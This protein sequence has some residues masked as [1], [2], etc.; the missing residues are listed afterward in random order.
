MPLLSSPSLPGKRKLFL[1]IAGIIGGALLLFSALSLFSYLFLLRQA[2]VEHLQSVTEL[3]AERGMAG[4]GLQ[5]TLAPDTGIRGILRN[6]P[7]IE[8]AAIYDLDNALLFAYA[9]PG[10]PAI[11]VRPEYVAKPGERFFLQHGRIKCQLS[12]PIEMQGRRLGTVHL[13]SNT[14]TLASHLGT[15]LAFMGGSFLLSLGLALIAAARLQHH[16]RQKIIGSNL[17]M[18]ELITASLQPPAEP[19]EQMS[20]GSREQAV[21][22]EPPGPAESCDGGTQ[23]ICACGRILPIGEESANSGVMIPEQELWSRTRALAFVGGDEALL[24]ELAMVFLDRNDRLLRNIETAITHGA[25]DDLLEAAHAYRGA[26]D[27]FS[28]PVLRQ[29]AMVLENMARN[30]QVDGADVYLVRLRENSHLLCDELSQ[31]IIEARRH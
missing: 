14:N 16:I 9:S 22:I 1:F 19:P 26:V 10:R 7:D 17:L 21:R 15:F 6:N 18:Q 31:L 11:T 23:D 25:A 24:R 4:L 20:V 2:V 27:H 12:Y 13:R 8:A 5:R 3:V 30:G 29:L 28:S